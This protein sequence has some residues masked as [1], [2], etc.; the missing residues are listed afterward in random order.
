[1]SSSPFSDKDAEKMEKLI[2]EFDVVVNCHTGA[3]QR[4]EKELAEFSANKRASEGKKQTAARKKQL[5]QEALLIH[6]GVPQEV[7][8]LR[9]QIL[10][11]KQE[12]ERTDITVARQKELY[13]LINFNTVALQRTC[14]HQFVLSKSGYKE[15]ETYDQSWVYGYRKCLVCGFVEYATSVDSQAVTHDLEKWTILDKNEKRIMAYP[16]DKQFDSFNIWRPLNEILKM[17][18]DSRVT[19]ML[20]PPA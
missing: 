18:V 6:N 4:F 15:Y 5:L 17:L 16:H 20:K 14:T 9:Q 8:D 10:E 3:I 11:M 7:G 19:E 1:M 2:Y 12:A 13:T